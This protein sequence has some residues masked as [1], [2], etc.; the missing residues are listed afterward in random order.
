MSEKLINLTCYLVIQEIEDILKEYPE[1]PYQAIFTH[2]VWRQTLT[3]HVLSQVP[4][5][6]YTIMDE[7]E[8]LPKNAKFLYSSKEEQIFLETLI[9]KSIIQ[10]VQEYFCTS[11]AS[12]LGDSIQPSKR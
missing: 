8:E 11:K 3:N 6:Y 4:N 2:P 10:V 5:H 7:S 9:R 1:N 12:K